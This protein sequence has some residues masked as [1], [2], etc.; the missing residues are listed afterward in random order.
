MDIVIV[1]VGRVF[2]DASLDSGLVKCFFLLMD[3]RTLD[4]QPASDSEGFGHGFDLVVQ[5]TLV[6]FH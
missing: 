6:D 4:Q 5:W 3:L 2:F 1:Y